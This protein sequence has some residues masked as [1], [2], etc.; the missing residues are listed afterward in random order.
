[1]FAPGPL[2]LS[3][4]PCSS[5]NKHHRSTFHHHHNHQQESWQMGLR[6]LSHCPEKPPHYLGL[7]LVKIAD[8][9]TIKFYEDTV[10]KRPLTR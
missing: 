5:T 3:L 6:E 10:Q 9:F 8:N 4:V 2:V 7:L 1:M